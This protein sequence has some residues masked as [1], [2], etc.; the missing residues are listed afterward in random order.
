MSE[1]ITFELKN[2]IARIILNRP[3]KKNALTFEMLQRLIEIGDTLKN[4]ND[5][6]CVLIMGIEG[7]FCAGIDFN[8][9]VELA[10]NKSFLTSLM[11]P[12]KGQ[13]Y[14][15]LQKP[16]IIWQELAVPVIAILEGPVFGAGLQLALGADIRISNMTAILSIMEL[17]WGLI[18]DMGITQ[19]L[20]K[21]MCYD[22]ALL[23]T[24]T[25]A[26]I[27]A[28]DA[29]SMGLITICSNEPYRKAISLA[30]E[31]GSKSLE[32]VRATKALYQK[33]WGELTDEHLKLEALLQTKLIGSP[34]Q[35]EAVFANLEKRKP[36][37]QKF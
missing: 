25:S 30:E 22:Q 19:T 9:F 29:K 24:L 31:L 32:A 15:Q 4:E 3:D 7:N 1:L 14:N 12:L 18:P 17:K 13:P 10:K 27:K 37:F 5:L 36:N 16:C 6:S 2:S 28:T 20:P 35:M 21:L 26:P 34:N 23:A 33:A 11:A 8:N